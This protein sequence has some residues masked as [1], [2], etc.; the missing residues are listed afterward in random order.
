MS[1]YSASDFAPVSALDL[2]RRCPANYLASDEPEGSDLAGAV[3]R[4]ALMAGATRVFVANH[5]DW[6]YVVGAPDWLKGL[7][8]FENIEPFPEGGRNAMR[9][10][11]LLTA[12]ARDV[13][14]GTDGT[15]ERIKGEA[16]PSLPGPAF[17]HPLGRR[18]R[19]W[20]AFRL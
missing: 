12:F 13:A 19:R 18:P 14:T 2:I 11:V 15:L 6:W 20:I 7:T 9:P 17:F 5:D 8:Q 3:A 10:E 16:P 1:T 4:G